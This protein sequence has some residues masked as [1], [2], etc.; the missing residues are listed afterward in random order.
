[1]PPKSEENRLDRCLQHS[2]LTEWFAV[3]ARRAAWTAQTSL[4]PELE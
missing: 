4:L 1:M 2:R 3:G